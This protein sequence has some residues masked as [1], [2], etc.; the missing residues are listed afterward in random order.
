[1][2]MDDLCGGLEP[3]DPKLL[4][5][6]ERAMREEIIPEIERVMRMRAEAAQKSRQW[7]IGS[8]ALNDGNCS[9]AQAR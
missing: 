1:M 2:I 7:I 5:E 8:I 9:D 3:V 4:E 6:Y